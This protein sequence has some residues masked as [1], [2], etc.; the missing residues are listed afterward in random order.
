MPAC[1]T[2]LSYCLHCSDDDDDDHKGG[3]TAAGA[4]AVSSQ[5]C[6]LSLGG[7]APQP[8]SA[9]APVAL[10]GAP[11]TLAW[12]LGEGGS[13][14]FGFNGTSDGESYLAVGFP[15]RPGRMSGASAFILMDSPSA[16]SG[17]PAA[18]C[19]ALRRAVLCC[20]VL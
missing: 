7:S 3:S 12:S 1:L 8:F 14:T 20:A 4:G 13:V 2:C 9:C 6:A 19:A 17:E 5:G 11:L 15:S 18:C 16:T 10:G